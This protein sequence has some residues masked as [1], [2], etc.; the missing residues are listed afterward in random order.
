LLVR[1]HNHHIPRLLHPLGFSVQRPRKRLARADAP[2]RELWLRVRLLAIKKAARC[3]GV[4]MFGD[5][6]SFWLDGYYQLRSATS[7]HRTATAVTISACSL[8]LAGSG[9][10]AKSETALSP[11]ESIS[12]RCVVEQCLC[13]L[14]V[15]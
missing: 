9:S 15:P 11:A 10:L 13:I 5:E 2:A 14:S 1:Y 12:S 6:A 4:V 7:P 3:R 8:A